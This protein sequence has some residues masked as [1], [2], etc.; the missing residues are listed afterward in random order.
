MKIYLN[1]HQ[2]QSDNLNW[3]GVAFAIYTFFWGG[4]IP[5]FAQEQ[6]GTM[7]PEVRE[8]LYPRSQAANANVP[9]NGQTQ[10]DRNQNFNESLFDRPHHQSTS[11]AS[12]ELPPFADDAIRQASFKSPATF[13]SKPEVD[14]IKAQ[15]NT[16]NYS[17]RLETTENRNSPP[18]PVVPGFKGNRLT[19]QGNL[20]RLQLDSNPESASEFDDMVLRSPETLSFQSDVD[21][22][23]ESIPNRSNYSGK[24]LEQMLNESNQ[25]LQAKRSGRATADS[26]DDDWS[27]EGTRSLNPP[28][29]SASTSDSLDFSEQRRQPIQFADQLQRIAIS[30]CVVL[31]L[32]VGF[33][34]TAQRWIAATRKGDSATQSSSVIGKPINKQSGKIVIQNQL[35]LDSKSILYLVSVGDQ[36][37]L[38]ATDSAGIKSVVPLKPSFDD[39]LDNLGETNEIDAPREI[40]QTPQSEPDDVAE[41]LERPDTYSPAAR[42]YLTPEPKSNSEPDQVETEMRRKLAELLGGEAFRD[43]L[44]Q[45]TN[46]K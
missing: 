29:F 6:A 3:I 4:L 13:D 9:H 12:T 2:S 36:Q 42:R 31:M 23:V 34:V 27:I 28:P 40:H 19:P 1:L 44:L 22:P 45:Q 38:V 20:D 16:H 41:G 15:T 37:V 8:A 30:L 5:T 43:I 11:N 17:P 18:A 33:V 46:R 24:T 26:V 35:R 25:S 7:P 32:G 39:L 10:S 21:T 14:A